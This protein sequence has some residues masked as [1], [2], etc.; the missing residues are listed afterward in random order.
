MLPPNWSYHPVAVFQQGS[1]PG[2]ETGP[3]V[4]QGRRGQVQSGSA[5]DERFGSKRPMAFLSALGRPAYLGL[6]YH[7]EIGESEL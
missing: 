7:R 3:R 1:A 5:G 6:I 4:E 2:Q